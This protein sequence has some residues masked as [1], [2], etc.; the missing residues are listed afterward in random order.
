MPT[1]EMPVLPPRPEPDRDAWLRDA[2]HP[3]R[4]PAP[5]VESVAG[6]GAFVDAAPSGRRNQPPAYPWLAR[7]SGW[8][9]TVVLRVTIEADGHPSA[10][11]IVRSSGYP[12]LDQA[13]QRAVQQWE[14]LPAHRGG[15]A[16]R[17]AV[18][19]PIRFQLTSSKPIPQG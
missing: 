4:P 16:V 15:P 19:L 6:R 2:L 18:E 8:E 3:S 17:S 12:I 1:A 9:G 14:F 11:R 13:A 10:A 7:I 5:S